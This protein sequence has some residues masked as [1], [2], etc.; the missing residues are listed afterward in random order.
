MLLSW[1]SRIARTR[2]SVLSLDPNSRSN[3]T[4]GSFSDI[5]GSVGVSHDSVLLYA[6]L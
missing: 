2:G 4:R 3:T 1:R 6:Q 5:S